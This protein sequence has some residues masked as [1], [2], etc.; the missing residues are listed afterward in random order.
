VTGVVVAV[1]IRVT[2]FWNVRACSLVEGFWC[3]NYVNFISVSG[4]PGNFVP[5]GGCST[6]SAEDR[7]ERTGIWGRWPLVR[8]SGRSCNFIQEISFRIVK[9]S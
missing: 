5:G 4:V 6:N 2:V 9:F 3:T 1:N 7:T 8:G